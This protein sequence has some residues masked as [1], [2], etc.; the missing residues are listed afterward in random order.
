MSFVSQIAK[1][2]KTDLSVPT[3]C[4][5]TDL[6]GKRLV[7][8]GFERVI[9]I[10]SERIE[11]ALKKQTLSVVGLDLSLAEIDGYT[12]VVDGVIGGVYRER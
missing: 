4:T 7:I 2:V 12:A 5:V 10:S 11:F 1:T 8:E 6:D 3:A 9:K